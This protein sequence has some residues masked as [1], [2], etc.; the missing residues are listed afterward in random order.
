[1]LI[2]ILV[3]GL[4]FLTLYPDWLRVMLTDPPLAQTVANHSIIRQFGVLAAVVISL[5]VL[6]ARRWEYWQLGGA[7]AGILTPY[8]MPGVCRSS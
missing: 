3:Y 7:L 2:S 5:L 6:V 8:G 4:P 1:M